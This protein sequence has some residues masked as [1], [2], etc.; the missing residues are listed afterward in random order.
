MGCLTL[1]WMRTLRPNFRIQ[2]YRVFITQLVEKLQQGSLYEVIEDILP[3]ILNT[4]RPACLFTCMIK[5]ILAVP[6]KG[7]KID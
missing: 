6:Q 5:I 4:N 7:S 1:K 3:F 2:L